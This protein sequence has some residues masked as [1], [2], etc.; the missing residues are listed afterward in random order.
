MTLTRLLEI[1]RAL[2][3]FDESRGLALAELLWNRAGRPAELARSAAPSKTFSAP[4]RARACANRRFCCA[5]RKNWSAPHGRRR[6]RMSPKRL[7]ES[8]RVLFA[9]APARFPILAA[10]PGGCANAS[11][12]SIAK[13]AM[14]G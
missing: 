7:R 3:T 10:F 2:L 9:A 1:D 14:P 6:R 8:L 11:S 4:A 12:A 5:A 13:A